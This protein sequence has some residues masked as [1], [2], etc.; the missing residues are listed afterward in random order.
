MSLENRAVPRDMPG[1]R[2]DFTRH[3]RRAQ[4][5]DRAHHSDASPA[6]DR[7]RAERH[8]CHSRVDHPLQ[9]HG[10]RLRR[11]GQASLPAI[12]QR[13]FV[14]RRA[15]NVADSSRGL[16]GS[17]VQE[18]RQ[19]SRKRVLHSVLVACRGTHRESFTHGAKRP[20]RGVDRRPDLAFG[21]TR[22]R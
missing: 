18:T 16:L 19:L 22:Q 4:T 9:D 2:I 11:C 7:I 20:D 21:H 14:E 10:R 8:A 15:P 12:A 3:E 17:N 13:T 6:R 5:S 1:M